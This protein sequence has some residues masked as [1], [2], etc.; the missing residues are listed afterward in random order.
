VTRRYADTAEESLEKK[1]RKLERRRD[2]LQARNPT[3]YALGEA[4]AL[5]FAIT[6]IEEFWDEAIDLIEQ[7]RKD[8]Q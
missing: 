6:L 8:R 1:V 5:D 4:N 2:H 7:R 3:G